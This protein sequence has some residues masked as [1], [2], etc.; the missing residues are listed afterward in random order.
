[1]PYRGQARDGSRHSSHKRHNRPLPGTS[2]SKLGCN[3]RPRFT[4]A[5]CWGGST[6]TPCGETA[7]ALLPHLRARGL[8]HPGPA[9]PPRPAFA[10]L[11]TPVDDDRTGRP[12]A[13]CH[14]HRRRRL[15][16][17]RRAPGGRPAAFPCWASTAAG[18]ASSPTSCRRTCSS[19]WMPRWKVAANRTTGRCWKR[20][21]IAARRHAIRSQLALND[22]V[23][24]KWETGRI[25][26][27]ETRVDGRFVNTHGGDGLVVA[28]ATGSTAY[29]LSC[30]GPIVDPSLDVLVV[31][32]ICPHTLADRP[33]VVSRPQ[34]HLR[35]AARALRHARAG[36]LRW[37]GVRRTAARRPAGDPRRPRIASRCC[38]R[39]ATTISA[40]CA[41][42][43]TG[44]AAAPSTNAKDGTTMLTH[45]QIRDLA[46]VDSAG[47]RLQP[48]AL[49]CSPARPAP[50]SPSW[51]MR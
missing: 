27:F 9:V 8:D 7:A 13:A 32:P 51:S 19:A 35:D 26:D 23:L 37:R 14:R 25:L 44:A 6:R 34:H 17:L 11:A 15:A 36:H 2:P 18:W 22:V 31:V 38:I 40:C 45:L 43:C 20:A 47:A 46:I 30:G 10:D 29:A 49:P 50:A 39:P 4:P 24:A 1:M 42:S 21:L 28:S 48:A 33:I 41:P 12:R 3:E 5:P 16:A